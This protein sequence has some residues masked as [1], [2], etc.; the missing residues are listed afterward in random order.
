VQ[1]NPNANEFRSRFSD[2]PP[3]D[4]VSVGAA[5]IGDFN[6]DIAPT[7][8]QPMNC[9]NLTFICSFLISALKPHLLH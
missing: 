1:L 3:P 5:P 2:T 7:D 9:K 6:N 4:S 8:G